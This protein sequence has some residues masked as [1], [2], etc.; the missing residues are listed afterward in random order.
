MS[1]YLFSLILGF[2]G[3]AI[4]A[5]SGALSGHGHH[6]GGHHG[7]GHDVGDVSLGHGGAHGHLHAGHAHV[8]HAHGAHIHAGHA[9]G[10]GLAHN[11]GPDLAHGHD[12]AH[13]ADADAGGGGIGH[14]LAEFALS[15]LSPRVIFSILVGLGAT[16]LLADDWLDGVMLFLAALAGGIV[17]EKGMVSPVWNFFF[18]FASAPAMT[19][20][21]AVMDTARAVTGFDAQGQGLVAIELDGQVVQLL[22]TLRPEDR[23]AGVRV[24]TGDALLIEEVDGE[25]NRCV[26]SYTGTTA[27]ALPGR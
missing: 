10:H 1:F 8:G 16:G 19:L 14:T 15:F 20:E 24:R 22:A 25:R 4:M 21:S 3:L 2:A 18:R 11:P 9:H 17:F 6:G 13:G 5:L 12:V 26:V 27:A 7:H 23:A